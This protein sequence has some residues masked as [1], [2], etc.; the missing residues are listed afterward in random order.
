MAS[1]RAVYSTCRQVPPEQLS[2]HY[3]RWGHSCDLSWRIEVCCGGRCGVLP[4]VF[5][6]REDAELAIRGISGLGLWWSD[7]FEECRGLVEEFG[8]DRLMEICVESLAW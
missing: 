4:L 7:D 6:R 3:A 2:A 1:L 5:G 8:R